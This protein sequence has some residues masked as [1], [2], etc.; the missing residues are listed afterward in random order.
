MTYSEFGRR[1]KQNGSGGTDHGTAAPMLLIGGRV[2]GGLHGKRPSLSALGPNGDLKH[3]TDFRAVIRTV[4][5]HAL[6]AH[7]PAVSSFEK[8][9]LF[10]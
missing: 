5:D 10:T 8:L 6:Q 4:S 2:A 9:P 1:A 3:T 7:T